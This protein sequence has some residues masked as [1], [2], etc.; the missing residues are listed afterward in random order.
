MNTTPS[1]GTALPAILREWIPNAWLAKKPA[2]IEAAWAGALALRNGA[3]TVLVAA[4]TFAPASADA[5]PI[6]FLTF[7]WTH[8]EGIVMPL[9]WAWLRAQTAFKK[10][11]AP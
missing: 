11:A 7:L 1:S 5:S 2:T 8:W 9:V 10:A 4:Y 3:G 6:A